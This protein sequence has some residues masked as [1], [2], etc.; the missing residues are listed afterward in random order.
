MRTLLCCLLSLSL[1]APASAWPGRKKKHIDAEELRLLMAA[2]ETQRNLTIAPVMR[3]AEAAPAPQAPPMVQPAT[4]MLPN[5]MTEYVTALYV[6]LY[7]P[8]VSEQNKVILCNR[9]M[10]RAD[11]RGTNITS[12]ALQLLATFGTGALGARI[13]R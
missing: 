9:I 13:A 4:F 7:A 5:S 6:V 8:G 3:P 10:D 1:I 11:K 12:L 2:V